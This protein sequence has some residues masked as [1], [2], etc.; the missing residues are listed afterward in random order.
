MANLELAMDFV[1]WDQ[2][3]STPKTLEGSAKL[4]PGEPFL[5]DGARASKALRI[6]QLAF[7][8]NGFILGLL[9]HFGIR[10]SSGHVAISYDVCLNEPHAAIFWILDFAKKKIKRKR[11]FLK[12]TSRR[13]SQ[14][15][16]TIAATA[17][18]LFHYWFREK[19][20]KSSH[21]GCGRLVR[22]KECAA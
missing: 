16:T 19:V 12:K 13:T 8:K 5:L 6:Q 15:T 21:Y 11:T 17:V 7:L 18:A 20:R 9:Y 2:N 1:F 10:K 22:W 14:S 4:V 3:I